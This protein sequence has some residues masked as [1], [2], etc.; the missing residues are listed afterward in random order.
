MIRR[1]I[2]IF[3][4][5]V[6]G[7]LLPAT[8][9]SGAAAALA[10]PRSAKS[11]GRV[12]DLTPVAADKRKRRLRPAALSSLGAVGVA[13]VVAGCGAAS[14]NSASPAATGARTTPV[15]PASAVTTPAAAPAN[16]PT[17]AAV[18]AA[19]PRPKVAPNLP[20]APAGAP[21][22]AAT[23]TPK[24][25]PKAPAAAAPKN[26]DAGIPQGNGGDADPDNTG[27]PNDG[28]GAI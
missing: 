13:L 23:P 19:T 22:H 8:K 17:R 20:A 28:D 16:A 2:R 14:T 21:A 1:M 18:A 6:L 5:P 27:G 4:V 9:L 24:T 11:R 25:A 3:V 26:P 12:G 7:G 10:R 15:A